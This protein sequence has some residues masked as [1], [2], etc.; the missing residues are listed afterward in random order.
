MKYKEKVRGLSEEIEKLTVIQ[1][2]NLKISAEIK[3]ENENLK[4]KI[5][6]S[7]V[8]REEVEEK[9]E[10]FNKVNEESRIREES[11]LMI[12]KIK[13]KEIM[14][15]KKQGISGNLK[16]QKQ[17]SLHFNKILL[18]GE[19]QGKSARDVHEIL[20]YNKE[21]LDFLISLDKKVTQLTHSLGLDGILVLTDELSY[22]IGSKKVNVLV[23][24]GQIYIRFGTCL[25]PIETFLI[26][27]CAQEVQQFKILRKKS[28]LR[29]VHK[30]SLSEL[31]KIENSSICKTF[32]DEFR[33]KLLTIQTSRSSVPRSRNSFSPMSQVLTAR[34]LNIFN[35]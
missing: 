25:K 29:T 6:E 13:D 7:N 4:K 23:K 28:D 8:E 2:K 35:S 32:D 5:E 33:K 10:K 34:N 21:K 18:S 9:L 24:K 26:N 15:L 17:E 14:R 12:L 19:N 11:I 3:K 20:N 22:S 27:N 16:I 31:E 1:A 30:K